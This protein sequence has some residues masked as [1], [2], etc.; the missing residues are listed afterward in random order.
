MDEQQESPIFQK[1]GNITLQSAIAVNLI[2]SP[3][4]LLSTDT[5][6]GKKKRH[7]TFTNNGYRYGKIYILPAADPAFFF[8]RT[9]MF[10]FL[11]FPAIV[12]ATSS[13]VPVFSCHLLFNDNKILK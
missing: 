11:F 9:F 3:L 6:P 7:S 2:F 13:A 5:L 1:Q 4:K 10:A 12:M 8:Q